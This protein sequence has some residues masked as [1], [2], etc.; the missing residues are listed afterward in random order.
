MRKGV[1]HADRNECLGVFSLGLDAINP[2]VEEGL[3][4]ILTDRE[5]GSACFGVALG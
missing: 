3:Q 1:D 5:R 2:Y 4:I